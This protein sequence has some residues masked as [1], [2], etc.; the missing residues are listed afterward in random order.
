MNLE[1]YNSWLSIAR[2]FSR[3]QND[4]KDLL[5]ECLL[6]AIKQERLD[7]NI[8]NNRKW[9]T[10][11]L[12]NQATMMAR[13]EFRRRNRE[14]IMANKVKS[15]SI[16][17]LDSV[18]QVEVN[19]QLLNKLTPSTRKV[20][21]LILSGF[22]RQEICSA[23]KLS[24]DALRQRLSM[25]R[26]SFKKLPKDMQKEA[27]ATAYQRRKENSDDLAFGLIRRALYRL[28]RDGSGIGTHDPDGHLLIIKKS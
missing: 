27:I 22:N 20:M 23:L 3:S 10:G 2:K 1:I 7:F 25:I 24:S 4:A 16:L 17:N 21:T 11:V 13:S 8:E 28:L 12:K 15:H 14:Q 9:F 18:L 19:A 6:I 5:Q 26:K